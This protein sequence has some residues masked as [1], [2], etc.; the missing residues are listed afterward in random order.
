MKFK[1]FISIFLILLVF[2]SGCINESGI[3]KAETEEKTTFSADILSASM[4]IIPEKL[5][6]NE[7]VN[8]FI[9][10]TNPSERELRNVVVCIYGYGITESC[11]KRSVYEEEEI[12]F[13]FEA[14]ALPENIEKTEYVYARIAFRDSFITTAKFPVIDEREYSIKLREGEQIPEFSLTASLSPISVNVELSESPVI[15]SNGYAEFEF[16]INIFNKGTGNVF[17]PEKFSEEISLLSDE[18]YGKAY[19]KIIAPEG[20][21]ISCE[22]EKK[23]GRYV[24]ELFDN[25]DSIFCNAKIKDK[26]I[27]LEKIFPVRFEIEYAYYFDIKD[28]YT[29]KGKGGIEITP[30]PE[31][32]T[33]TPPEITPPPEEVFEGIDI[34]FNN[35]GETSWEKVKKLPLNYEVIGIK[36]SKDITD[37]KITK[38]SQGGG[39][40]IH[41][42]LPYEKDACDLES[43]FASPSEQI[44]KLSDTFCGTNELN[45]ILNQGYTYFLIL[46][47]Y[48]YTKKIN[49]EIEC[50]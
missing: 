11:K 22:R 43:I 1:S 19:L 18:D 39:Q 35:C 9:Y 42:L 37:V 38:I 23:Q 45:N 15:S 44:I 41:F 4:E 30:P 17:D 36:V 14:P 7:K 50:Q 24:I 3:L 34:R 5:H 32:E 31:E 49:V 20:M 33:T 29:V 48:R 6:S 28:S 26:S 12:S 8:V 40:S 21:E 2:F 10:L 25:E 16:I 47:I 13:S 46:K 27:S